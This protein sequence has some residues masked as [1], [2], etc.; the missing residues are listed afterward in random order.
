MSKERLVELIENN[1][2]IDLEDD[3]AHNSIWNEMFE[4]LSK[5]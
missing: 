4:A 3:F 1:K 2:N 5:F